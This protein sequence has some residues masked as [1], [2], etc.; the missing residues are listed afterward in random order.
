MRNLILTSAL[1]LTTQSV[2]ADQC[3]VN[4][5]GHLQL[6]NQILTIKTDDNDRIIINQQ[7]DLTVNGKPIDLSN[8]QQKWVK[9][10]YQGLYTAAPQAAAIAS[11]AL[12]L[13]STAL[14]QTFTELLGNDDNVSHDITAKLAEINQKIQTRFYAEDGSVRVNSDNFEDGEWASQEWEDELSEGI[15]EVVTA[16]I[17]KLMIAVGTEMLFGNSDMDGFE[18]RMDNFANEIEQ[19]VEVQTAAIEQKADAFCHSLVRVDDAES[20]L[21]RNI[22]ELAGLDVLRVKEQHSAM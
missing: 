17:G 3:E 10:Y 9:N 1:L 22:P 11:D 16:S 14:T 7:Y 2:F 6:E 13:A 12:N 5:N 4:F 19:K 15:E 8:Q 20:A 21:Q 18:Q